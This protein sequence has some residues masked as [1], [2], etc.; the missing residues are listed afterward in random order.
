MIGTGAQ[1]N[2]QLEHSLQEYNS[3]IGAVSAVVLRY[4]FCIPD[5]AIAVL[6]SRGQSGWPLWGIGIGHPKIC[7]FGMRILL[8]WLL[9][10]TAD[11]GEALTSRILLF[12]RDIY[13]FKGNLH[14]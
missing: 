8:G 10:R 12:A 2:F 13:I 14:L 5:I 4:L 1:E 6:E 7:L 3:A 11:M 9:L